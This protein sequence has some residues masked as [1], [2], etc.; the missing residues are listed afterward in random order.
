MTFDADRLRDLGGWYRRHLLEDVMAF[1][2]P[3]TRDAECGGYLT[4]FDRRGAVTDHDKYVW[5]QGRQLYMFAALHGQVQASETW[6]DLARHG[7]DFLVRHA[8]AGAGRWHYH[9]DRQGRVRKGTISIFSDHFVLGG[10]CEL[11]RATGSDA[12]RGLIEQTYAAI[13]RNTL[14]PAFKDLFHG[15]W[16]PRLQRHG[17]FMFGLHAA[18]VARPVLGARRVQMLADDCLERVLH[19]FA[20]DEHRALFESVDR[21]G[22]VVLDDAEGRL[23]NPG[24]TLESMWFCVEEGLY[25]QDRAVVDRA[26]TVADWA[27]DLGHDAEHGGIVSFL[28][29]SGG[30]P[31]QTDWHRETG[32]MW[33][34]KAWWVHAEALYALALAAVLGRSAVHFGRFLELH[35][36]CQ[37][38]FFDAEHGEWFAELRRDGTPKLTDKGTVWKAAYHLPRALMKVML[39]FEDPVDRD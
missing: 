27:Y 25:R 4:C 10:L 21:D 35:D 9:L 13:E 8:W 31:K 24:H 28:D 38:H 7:R 18:Q 11:A 32:M 23:L 12:D 6:L 2:V 3:R 16:H 33:H 19:V 5:F 17:V 20:S 30:E 36:W 1:W 14:D 22:R 26:L 29:A 39:L 15:T 34:D 37:R